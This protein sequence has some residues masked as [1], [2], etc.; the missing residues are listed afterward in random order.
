MEGS[1]KDSDNAQKKNILEDLSKEDLIKRYKNLLV[2]AQ[3]AKQAKDEAGEEI[4]RLKEQLTKYEQDNKKGE[5]AEV[6]WKQKEEQFKNEISAM[7]EMLATLTNQKL[8][9]TMEADNLKKQNLALEK[10]FNQLKINESKL[11]ETTAKLQAQIDELE[12]T[13]ES[14]KRQTNRLS[15]E[16]ES[17]IQQMEALELEMKRKE[18]EFTAHSNS[19]KVKQLQDEVEAL[20]DELDCVKEEDARKK[21]QMKQKKLDQQ[22]WNE[23]LKNLSIENEKVLMDIKNVKENNA[24]LK[25]LIERIGIERDTLSLKCENL[26][27][28]NKIANDYIKELELEKKSMLFINSHLETEK[29]QLTKVNENLSDEIV[30]IKSENKSFEEEKDKLN[31]KLQ[32]VI[33]ERQHL[34]DERTSIK[35]WLQNVLDRTVNILQEKLDLAPET[36][37]INI[38]DKQSG[39]LQ[40]LITSLDEKFTHI[41][42]FASGKSNVSDATENVCDEFKENEKDGH[43]VN[44]VLDTGTEIVLTDNAVL[45]ARKYFMKL[46]AEI[47]NLSAV[48]S[49]L[50]TESE[51]LLKE[52]NELKKLL[53]YLKENC[54]IPIVTQF[55]NKNISLFDEYVC[56]GSLCQRSS[57]LSQLET[58]LDSYKKNLDLKIIEVAHIKKKSNDFEEELRQELSHCR[59]CLSQKNAELNLVKE[60]LT[61]ALENQKGATVFQRNVRAI[62][63]EKMLSNK[64]LEEKETEVLKLKEEILNL[65]E[66]KYNCHLEIVRLQ[67]E[68]GNLNVIFENTTKGME[69]LKVEITH[70]EQ[71]VK[72]LQQ[73]LIANKDKCSYLEKCNLKAYDE[74]AVAEEQLVVLK[75]DFLNLKNQFEEKSEE[76]N[77][78]RGELFAHENHEMA[79]NDTL[80]KLKLEID[81]LKNQLTDKCALLHNSNS[82]VETLKE[83]TD[84]NVELS[85]SVSEL[86]NQIVQNSELLHQ[87]DLQLESSNEEIIRLTGEKEYLER[88]I[89]IK[90]KLL[91]EK[92]LEMKSTNET[93]K[94]VS[95][96]LESVQN[97]LDS[98]ILK[99]ENDAQHFKFLFDE[100]NIELDAA[101]HELNCIKGNSV[102]MGNEMFLEIS[103][104]QSNLDMKNKEVETLRTTLLQSE[105]NLAQALVKLSK[106]ENEH[107]NNQELS[108]TLKAEIL[109]LNSQLSE[110]SLQI[111][112]LQIS[113]EEKCFEVQSLSKQTE[114]AISEMEAMKKTLEECQANNCK[115][116][117]DLEKE[118]QKANEKLNSLNK[119]KEKLMNDVQNLNCLISRK[120]EELE[121]FI[122]AQEEIKRL[123]EV[124]MLCSEDKKRLE[125]E[126]KTLTD[127]YNQKSKEVENLSSELRDVKCALTEA[128]S[129]VNSVKDV[130][131]TSSRKLSE[132]DEQLRDAATKLSLKDKEYED[133]LKQIEET[134]KSN[135]VLN[136][137]LQ[138][139]KCNL[140]SLSSRVKELNS[141]RLILAE[142]A[143]TFKTAVLKSQ[144]ET[145]FPIQKI[146]GNVV[147]SEVAIVKKE[148]AELLGEMN[149]MNQVL[150]QRGETI[151]KLKELNNELDLQLK[152]TTNKLNS[153]NE[154]L[155]TKL[156]ELEMKDREL[157]EFKINLDKLKESNQEEV[158]CKDE[159]INSL[160]KEL[161]KFKECQ[162]ELETKTLTLEAREETIHNLE[163]ELLKLTKKVQELEHKDKI[164]STL[165]EEIETLKIGNREQD[166]KATAVDDQKVKD[167]EDEVKRLK[168]RIQQLEREAEEMR[169]ENGDAP[170]EIMSSSTISRAEESARLKDLEES[171]EERYTKLRTVAVRLKKKVSELTTQQTQLETDKKK[172]SAEK[173]D[174]QAKITQL[175]SHAKNLQSMQQ[176]YDR[177]QDELESQKAEVK[178]LTKTLEAAVTESTNIKVQLEECQQERESKCRELEM[179]SKEKHNLETANKELA[180]QVLSLKKEK[181][182]EN[183]AKKEKERELKRL[184]EEMRAKEKR[185]TEEI[186]RHKSTQEQLEISKQ[187]CK[188][189]SVLSLE[190]DDYEL[191]AEKSK[192]KELDNHLDTQRDISRGLQEQIS[193]LEQRI[194][195]EESRSKEVKDQLN[196][197]RT[198]VSE[199]EN[200][201]QEQESLIAE[202]TSQIEL[203]QE[204]NENLVLELSALAAE[205]QKLVE[206]GRN[207]QD[208]LVRQVHILEEHVSRLKE[209]LAE[210]ETELGDL[211]AEF[212]NYKIL[213]DPID[214]NIRICDS[215]SE[216]E[217]DDDVSDGKLQTLTIE[218]NAIQEERSRIS[219]RCQ[220]LV[221]TVQD[222]RSQNSQLE[223]QLQDMSIE[224]REALKSQK[225]QAETLNQCYK[226]QLEEFEER[227]QKETSVLTQR[228]LEVE[229]QLRGTLQQP[230]ARGDTSTRQLTSSKDPSNSSH[231]NNSGIGFV[232]VKPTAIQQDSENRLV[233][234]M[235]EREEGEGSE[236]VDSSSPP[237]TATQDHSAELIPLDKLLSTPS[238]DDVSGTSAVG[239]SPG[240]ELVKTKEQLVVSECRIKHLTG[241]LSEAE[242]DLA[243]LTQ[244]NQV[245][246][247]EIRRQQRSVE[248]EQHAQNFEYL[249]NV[250]LKFVTLQGG[251]ERSR[252][253]PVLNTILKLSPEETN[254]LNIVAKGGPD[255]QSGGRGWGSYLSL[256]SGTQ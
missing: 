208:G 153:I 216:L 63:E 64:H 232:P 48:I 50:E 149:E 154:K 143:Q 226:Q 197:S 12:T 139:M 10:H 172:L 230:S 206:S 140:E 191:A 96:T 246:K 25:V 97:D 255:L 103:N 241:L 245:L 74:K 211:R 198:K 99:L 165:E 186:E 227:L 15:N 35:S 77:I 67:T 222:L 244:Q 228:L 105:S 100:K 181:D 6:E 201:A 174:L 178:Q 254:Q 33:N 98:K 114:D 213:E 9:F 58:E 90:C 95:N 134:R 170:S 30:T 189:R 150:K 17:L 32:S 62:C 68:L 131:L 175:S 72:N 142:E 122:K 109:E 38:C 2:I 169:K 231:W 81:E 121:H 151:S 39:S 252:L 123:T 235:I 69:S 180:S 89:E 136:S 107:L 20:R 76:A 168:S 209:S 195:S 1:L 94:V 243:K 182:A 75:Q 124:H 104:L 176:E 141:V 248:R 251:D 239:G 196:I 167:L 82:E 190:M 221:D 132:M 8:Q 40:T 126:L 60:E 223:A 117:N 112:K 207:Q 171:F 91:T 52:N 146:I 27:E 11:L 237:L 66:Q 229:E 144:Q 111:S 36:E 193:L 138:L 148:N 184:E 53:E 133:K 42:L 70:L 54:N 164:I 84:K 41:F 240:V 22:T 166:E 253:V 203:H 250:V 73:D 199:L 127:C 238:E 162:H 29:L 212:G 224:H 88:E 55:V 92:E 234:S 163:A 249:K 4:K 152:D 102:I 86:R 236:S 179:C 242:R 128:T 187:E 173:S 7:E 233:M 46:Y 135:D 155:S 16:N 49:N 106:N 219:Q 19:D 177:L 5:N 45:E 13:A 3:K 61:F 192:V 83:V 200:R 26:S 65:Q 188:K 145:W 125:E 23:E 183:M 110:K 205:K 31:E 161:V 56:K 157:C 202:L 51:F 78:L 14:Y 80:G 43:S 247:E 225:L 215:G 256:W 108:E 159:T 44:K 129:E 185:L 158:Q 101:K 85:S 119:E 115:A 147:E 156:S 113:L 18:G 47:Q 24:E 93:L 217:G 120:T 118:L 37:G 59:E 160:E 130:Q 210:R 218:N 21:Y 204:K 71:N 116:Q 137:K 28:T 57:R 194:L 87:K 214:E 220:E 34:E 79:L